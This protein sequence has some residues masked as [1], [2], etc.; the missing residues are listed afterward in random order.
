MKKASFTPKEHYLCLSKGNK[1]G[2]LSN[3]LGNDK[4]A[5]MNI[6]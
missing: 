3:A 5:Q 1:D 4:G 6:Y 2:C